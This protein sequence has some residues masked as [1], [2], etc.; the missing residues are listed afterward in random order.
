[1]IETRRISSIAKPVIRLCIFDACRWDTIGSFDVCV[2]RRLVPMHVTTEYDLS[3]LSKPTEH[4]VVTS[5]SEAQPSSRDAHRT[6]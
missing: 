3:L 5:V 6:S 4:A 1:M 2:D